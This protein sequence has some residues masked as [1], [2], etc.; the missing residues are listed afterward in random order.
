MR[1]GM[2]YLPAVNTPQFDWCE[3]TFD[4]HPQ[5]VPPIY[6]PEVAARCIV[7]ATLNGRRTK[8]V[9]V[10]N[11]LLVVA[12]SNALTFSFCLT[13]RGRARPELIC[14]IECLNRG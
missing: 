1:L 4:R 9:G 13:D 12:G 3:T 2:V 11:K 14:E 8:V 7:D 10:W 6:Q 5:P